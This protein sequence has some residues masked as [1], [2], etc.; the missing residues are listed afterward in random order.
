MTY[1]EIINTSTSV[2][3][4]EEVT[5]V[6]EVDDGP[7]FFNLGQLINVDDSGATAGQVL[8]KLV[9]G[10]YGFTDAGAGDMQQTVYDPTGV[11]DDAFDM[12][13][14][15]E[16]STKLIL[17]GAERTLIANALQSGDNIS[18][19]TNDSGYIT[20]YIVTN[21][22][23]TGLNI[24]ELTNDSG[25][26]TSYTE[27]DPI[28]VASEAY[29]ITA[30]NITDLGN[31]S[32]TNTGDQDLSGLVPYTGAAFDVNLGSHDLT[33]ENGSFNTSN[34]VF[35]VSKFERRT[36]VTTGNFNTLTGVASTSLFKSTTTGDMGDGFGGGLIFTINDDTELAD[37]NYIARI[38]ARRD[39]ADN[40]G[41][42]QFW[43]GAGANVPLLTL[44]GDGKIGTSNTGANPSSDIH[45]KWDNT[46]TDVSSGLTLE[47]DGTGDALINFVL[48]GAERFM[49][50]ID[51]DDSNKFKITTGSDIINDTVFTINPA[52]GSMS[53]GANTPYAKYDFGGL[54]N[55]NVIGTPVMKIYDDYSSVSGI[56]MGNIDSTGGT[57]ADFR[58]MITDPTNHYFAFAQ[59]GI[60]NSQTLIGLDRKTTDMIFNN[61]GTVRDIAIFTA[62]TSGGYGNLVFGTSQ[63]EA[64]RIDTGRNTIIANATGQ[65][66]MIGT[67]NNP[68]GYKMIV[69]DDST[70]G[71]TLVLA[72]KENGIT[73]DEV[74]GS[75][76][77]LGGDDGTNDD[78]WDT[79][80]GSVV[81]RAFA[82][83]SHGG[84][85]RGGYFTISTKSVDD[86]PN[87]AATERLRIDDSGTT[88]QND[89][90]V[91]GTY[92]SL[93]I[94]ANVNSRS[95]TFEPA[96]GAV[97][98]TG[99]WMHLNRHSGLQ[100][101][102]GASSDSDFS[103]GGDDFYVDNSAG[104]VGIGTSS[105]EGI[106]S[107]VGTTY[108]SAPTEQ[109]IHFGSSLGWSNMTLNDTS[110]SFIDF[111]EGGVDRY[112]RIMYTNSTNVMSFQTNTSQRMELNSSGMDVTGSVT[113]D[114]F[115]DNSGTTS[116]LVRYGTSG[117]LED[118]GVTY[119]TS[120]GSMAISETINGGDVGLSITNGGTSGYSTAG[121]TLNNDLGAEG[122]YFRL[123]G[124][125][126]GV[127]GLNNLLYAK[128]IVGGTAF[129][130]KA[131]S[132][133][134]FGLGNTVASADD[135]VINSDSTVSISNMLYA[136]AGIDVTGNITVSGTVDG[137]DL[138]AIDIS[139]LN[140]TGTPSA[141]TFLR[142]DGSWAT[143]AGSGD[144]SKVGT[145]VD[146]QVGVWTGDG[147]IEGTAGFTYD[148]TTLDLT[149]NITLSGTVD[150][151]DIATDGSTQDSHIADS[152]IH[153]TQASISIPASQISDFDTEVANNTAVTANTAKVG[154]T[155]QISN[156]VEDTTPQLG[157]DVDW[158]SNGHKLVS[159]TVGG[160]NGNA[161]QLTGSNTWGQADASVEST[162]DGMLG[163][164]ISA[165]EV[166]THGVY[167][168]TG[169]TAGATYYL[170]ETAGAITTTAPTTSTSIVRVI[171]YA[172]STTE[173][174]V[175]P[176]DTFIEV[177]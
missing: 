15:V 21:S 67:D 147:T 151:R 159:Q 91:D 105:P 25:Y 133:I 42:I 107:I 154:V 143:P 7:Y 100:V 48:T 23:L 19:L 13:N 5:T 102:I 161:V 86:D 11:A 40:S 139:Y 128:N 129:V 79:V 93:V 122:V 171:G 58:F 167:T 9:S 35:P 31:L 127:S 126:T 95:F 148:G 120:T 104:R 26:I 166:L 94:N 43:G 144:V 32:G 51:N 157:G 37:S 63:I 2:V 75:L 173:L 41:G 142:G 123:Y 170:S 22:D 66:V 177:V 114:S 39:G 18:S 16:G 96:S 136:D 1:I 158:N 30:Q 45:F 141:A 46:S 81:L 98:S 62:Q 99:T 116:N 84:S 70:G 118:S 38:L 169:L 155:T 103:V 36:T 72:R 69:A 106:L 92:G 54:V 165:T 60:A 135:L 163:I 97:D 113:A 125:N 71:S 14:M 110:G 132:T 78:N 82:S 134:G 34:G 57:G 44:R 121:F 28:F 175:F 153:Y 85:D 164:R 20:D 33:I 156:V 8:T 149:G 64:M 119:T 6:I 74:L 88:I 168:T 115:I 89:L 108:P 29:N 111:S 101:A 117:L 76:I 59:P 56:Q 160:S 87:V 137:V 145:P 49:M 176:D 73:V 140:T 174:F 3:A 109:G 4:D 130:S 83:E 50:G 131:G 90:I 146:N 52:T 65:E 172:L 68:Q 61:G 17:T 112:G 124:S 150:G 53:F 24:S 55:T 10:N 80:D 12:D 138:Q 47:Q 27:T 152:T 77:F 162:A